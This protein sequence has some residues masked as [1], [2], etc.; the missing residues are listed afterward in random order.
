VYHVF[1]IGDGKLSRFQTDC[2]S[3]HEDEEPQHNSSKTVDESSL[4][5]LH[6]IIA[7]DESFTDDFNFNH[8][9][10]GNHDDD[11]SSNSRDDSFSKSTKFS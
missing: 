7:N 10:Q 6:R 3:D 11:Y 2:T 5:N 9:F 1:L 4:K 8:N